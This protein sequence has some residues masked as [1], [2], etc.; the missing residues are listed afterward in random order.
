V[1][2]FGAP[3][4]ESD[5]L[6]RRGRALAWALADAA[7]LRVDAAAR[8]AVLR[9]LREAQLRPKGTIAMV[10]SATRGA[11]DPDE[12]DLLHHEA[13]RSL[14]QLRPDAPQRP[15]LDALSAAQPSWEL[16]VAIDAD[17]LLVVPRL[18][19]LARLP[20]FVSE[21]EVAGSF[22]WASRPGSRL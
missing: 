3:S 4:N 20:D 5:S 9:S 7:L 19:A 11:L 15:W 12:L 1:P 6:L 22:E 2:L 16:P 17:E 10:F 18:S 14:D 8:A 13:R 21:I